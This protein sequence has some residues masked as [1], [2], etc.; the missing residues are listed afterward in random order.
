MKKIN[1]Q[2]ERIKWDYFELLKEAEGR[3]DATVKEAA[4]AL[5]R[6]EEHTGFKCFKTFRREQVTSFK[7]HLAKVKNART[8]EPLSLSTLSSTMNRLK[9]FFIWLSTQPGYK[10]RIQVSDAHYFRLTEKD[11]RAAKAQS[12]KSVAT[13]EQVSKAVLAMPTTT[14][15]EKR[16]Q[17]IMVFTILTGIRDDALISLKLKHVELEKGYI[18]QDPREVKTKFSKQIHTFLLPVGEDF[19]KIFSEWVTYLREDKL[20]GLNDPLFPK[21]LMG[22]DKNM[23]FMPVGLSHEHWKTAQPIRDIFKRAFKAVGLPYFNPH[24]F[25]DTLTHHAILQDL[26]LSEMKAFSQ[27]LGHESVF[28]TLGSYGQLPPEQQ[29]KLI[30]GMGKKEQDEKIDI[31]LKELRKMQ[32]K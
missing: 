17:A 20:F 28:I 7:R 31:L 13:L 6:F 19:R 9:A 10:S 14:E 23:G 25:R 21:T 16:D 27:N 26:P 29:K 1:A 2:N 5:Q 22:H 18:N 24:S 4:K 11:E 32:G 12:F 8:G 3:S 15:L 30:E